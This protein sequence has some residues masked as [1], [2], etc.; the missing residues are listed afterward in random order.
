MSFHIN[1]AFRIKTSNGNKIE[2]FNSFIR[3]TTQKIQTQ[4]I[5]HF[6]AEKSA[7]YYTDFVHNTYRNK[8][9]DIQL[10]DITFSKF[11]SND[12]NFEQRDIDFLKRNLERKTFI[13]DHLLNTMRDSSDFNLKT[14]YNFSVEVCFKT[15][16]Q[17]TYYIVFSHAN[18]LTKNIMKSLL[19]H[20]F[21]ENFNYYDKDPDSFENKSL[22]TKWKNRKKIWEKVVNLSTYQNSMNS[23]VIKDFFSIFNHEA[24]KSILSFIPSE[25]TRYLEHYK[26]KK[27]DDLY[28][29]KI[30]L[31]YTNK[32]QEVV[33]SLVNE[34]I[35]EVDRMLKTSIPEDFEVYRND[36]ITQNELLD[37]ITQ[38]KILF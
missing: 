35:R 13:F 11:L 29:E 19:E 3:T 30:Q 37:K 16:G 23:I 38:L 27:T 12:F 15:L 4:Y 7:H 14:P 10:S 18:E 5:T 25:D 21:V 34:C 36:F 8:K 32:P 31:K 6:I 20:D 9:S 22:Y 26:T 17:Y 24:Y 1:D 33:F 28:A 2:A